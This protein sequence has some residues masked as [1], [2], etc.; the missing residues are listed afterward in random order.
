VEKKHKKVS[1]AN[2]IA[3]ELKPPKIVIPDDNILLIKETQNTQGYNSV[4]VGGR[5]M[6]K[7]TQVSKS[8]NIH[9]LSL[10]CHQQS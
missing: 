1:F 2:P 7:L 3:T 9:L 5:L 4:K 10:A 6:N 8:L